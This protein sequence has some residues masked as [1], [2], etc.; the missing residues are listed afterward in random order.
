MKKE[1]FIKER[2]NEEFKIINFLW[3]EL[4]V[5]ENYRKKFKIYINSIDDD[6]SKKEYVEL[7][8]KDLKKLRELKIELSKEINNREKNIEI[9]KELCYLLDKKKLDLEK[10]KNNKL[11]TDIVSIIQNLRVDS[12]NCILIIKKIKEIYNSNSE[13]YNVDKIYKDH[14]YD[15]KYTLKMKKD[16]LFIKK[17][18]LNK[19][20]EMTN[21]KIDPFLTIFSPLKKE[22]ISNKIIIPIEDN[23]FNSIEICRFEIF[24]DNIFYKKYDDPYMFSINYNIIN[25]ENDI[26][27]KSLKRN[28]FLNQVKEVEEKTGKNNK[29]IIHKKGNSNNK[30]EKEDIKSYNSLIIKKDIINKIN[31]IE[32]NNIN[33]IEFKDI[34]KDNIDQK[35]K[36]EEKK[37]INHKLKNNK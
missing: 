7:E 15:K 14:L 22:N 17:T 13:K 3:D 30:K 24:E 25:K 8:K 29:Y 36:K 2:I 10:D 33:E 34:E 21:E 12:I 20:F 11:L 31:E 4:K 28:D 35:E 1:D 27:N 19:Y 37:S 6:N 26:M 5:S 23:L 16:M 9:L 18:S 32:N